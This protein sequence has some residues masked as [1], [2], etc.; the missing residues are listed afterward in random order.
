MYANQG[1]VQEQD[2]TKVTRVANGDNGG[3]TIKEMNV[4]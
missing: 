4:S 3:E 1:C 2:Y